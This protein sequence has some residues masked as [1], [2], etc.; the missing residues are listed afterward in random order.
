LLT[1][2]R[3]NETELMRLMGDQQRAP[4]DQVETDRFDFE[5]A[6]ALTAPFIVLPNYGTRCTTVILADRQGNWRF[7]E[8]RFGPGGEKT[9]ETRLSFLA[10]EPGA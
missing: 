6:Y 5:T 3:I 10:G 7:V 8:R 1:E 2:D 4:A 9:G